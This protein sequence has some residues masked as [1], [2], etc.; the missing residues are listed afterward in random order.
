MGRF[1]HV[2][3]LRV[4][5]KELAALR[6]MAAMR[7]C[8]VEELIRLEL[9]LADGD[10]DEPAPKRLKPASVDAELAP[11]QLKIIEGGGAGGLVAR[12]QAQDA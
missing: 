1:A 3:H 10:P 2:V 6:R 12:P 4:N 11:P 5:H 7:D 8:D 9:R